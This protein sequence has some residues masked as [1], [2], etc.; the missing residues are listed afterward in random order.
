MK[1]HYDHATTTTAG[2]ISV[3]ALTDDAEHTDV[4]GGLREGESGWVRRRRVG[5]GEWKGE[6]LMRRSNMNVER[7]ISSRQG[8][9]G[10]CELYVDQ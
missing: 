3:S 8:A 6:F 2:F 5:V 10:A 9:L 1:S 7:D 4:R